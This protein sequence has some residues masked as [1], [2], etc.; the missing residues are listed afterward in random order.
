MKVIFTNGCFDILHRGHLE[1]LKFCRSIG[2]HVVV[3]INSDDSV[4]KI[5][6]PD[7]PIFSQEDR[8]AILESLTCVDEVFVFHEKTPQSLI[9]SIN[10]DIIV[11]GSDYSPDKVIGNESCEVV[12]FELLDGYSTTKT[13]QD[14]T[15]R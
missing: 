12:I 1:L 2:D 4:R 13:I 14:I 10:P 3:G 7:R 5:K 8:K 11:K 6:G 15:N 9:N